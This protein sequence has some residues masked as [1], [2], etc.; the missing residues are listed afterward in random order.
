MEVI[1]LKKGYFGKLRAPG[2]RFDV[3]EGVKGSWFEPTEKAK[4]KRAKADAVPEGGAGD[5]A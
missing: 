2:D 5:L 3:P 1:A 4:Q